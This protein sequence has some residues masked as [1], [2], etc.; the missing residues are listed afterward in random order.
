M[1]RLTEIQK[2]IEELAPEEKEELREWLDERDTEL[3]M[4]WAKVAEERLRGI[5]SG[6]RKT[7]D[8]FEVF[9]EARRIAER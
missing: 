7:I 5:K 9:A 3:E 8:A 2:A 4:E 6:E 1:S